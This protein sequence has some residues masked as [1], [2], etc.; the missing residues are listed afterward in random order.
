[1]EGSAPDREGGEALGWSPWPRPSRRRGRRRSIW[2]RSRPR[3]I[4]RLPD[5]ELRQF[6]YQQKKKQQDS[7][8]KQKTTQ[9]KE[10][11]F[12]PNIDD[13]DYEFK[14]KTF[15]SFWRTATSEAT[16]QFRGREMARR[17]NG[18]KVLDRL[19]VDLDGKAAAM[20]RS[21]MLGNRFTRSWRRSSS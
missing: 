19:L 8:K 2:S 20:S 13:H 7:K 18:Q 11:K 12:R 14:I 10:V 5:H 17:E 3:R 1:M 4:L 21:E 6:I 9:V 15:S 16:V